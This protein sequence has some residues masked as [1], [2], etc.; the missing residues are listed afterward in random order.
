M[1]ISVSNGGVGIG[2]RKVSCTGLPVDHIIGA[3]DHIEVTHLMNERACLRVCA[4]ERRAPECLTQVD[5]LK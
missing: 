1:T 2:I 4:R 5:V 3:G